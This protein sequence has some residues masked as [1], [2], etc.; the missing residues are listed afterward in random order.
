VFE[1]NDKG[2]EVKSERCRRVLTTDQRSTKGRYA[3]QGKWTIEL[4]VRIFC[5]RAKKVS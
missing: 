3:Q 2:S 4:E 1:E 5:G